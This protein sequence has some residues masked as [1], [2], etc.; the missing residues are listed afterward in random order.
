MEISF[1]CR[2]TVHV[3]IGELHYACLTLKPDCP[4]SAAM[5]ESC[6]QLF[7]ERMRSI[8]RELPILTDLARDLTYLTAIDYSKPLKK[9]VVRWIV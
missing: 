3:L 1:F 7:L 8:Y 2:Y 9:I 4:S 6:S 5:L